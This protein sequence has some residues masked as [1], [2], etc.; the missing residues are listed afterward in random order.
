MNQS[1]ADGIPPVTSNPALQSSA[2]NP[3]QS[4]NPAEISALLNRIVTPIIQPIVNRNFTA[5]NAIPKA[6]QDTERLDVP[7]WKVNWN[8]APDNYTGY[9][10]WNESLTATEN[11]VAGLLRTILWR[12]PIVRIEPLPY[13]H[14]ERRSWAY[15]LFCAIIDV[16][17]GVMDK[18]PGP[19]NNTKPNKVIYRKYDQGRMQAGCYQVIEKL[20]E[21]HSIGASVTPSK[22]PTFKK[23]DNPGH[24]PTTPGAI[25]EGHAWYVPDPNSVV[26]RN[27]SFEERFTELCVSVTHYKT[28]ADDLIDGNDIEKV[29]YAPV[30]A[31]KCKMESALTSKKKRTEKTNNERRINN[32]VK[33][34]VQIP[35]LP[36]PGGR[37]AAGNPKRPSLQEPPRLTA[38]SALWATQRPQLVDGVNPTPAVS[39]PT[40]SPD[41]ITAALRAFLQG[42]VRESRNPP[43]VISALAQ[44]NTRALAHL[45]ARVTPILSQQQEAAIRIPAISPERIQRQPHAAVRNHQTMHDEALIDPDLTLSQQRQLSIPAQNPLHLDASRETQVARSHDHDVPDIQPESDASETHDAFFSQE[46]TASD[47]MLNYPDPIVFDNGWNVEQFMTALQVE[48]DEREVIEAEQGE[49]Q[50]RTPTINSTTNANSGMIETTPDVFNDC[51]NDPPGGQGKRWEPTPTSPQDRTPAQQ[52]PMRTN[53]RQA[54]PQR[55][56]PRNHHPMT[57]SQ[58]QTR[59]ARNSDVQEVHIRSSP[60]RANQK[61]GLAEDEEMNE[62]KRVKAGHLHGNRKE[63]SREH[64]YQRTR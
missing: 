36:V 18:F 24:N 2:P 53:I 28:I 35:M 23:K 61:R 47:Y 25:R 7:P 8:T 49:G 5:A 42:L 32:M 10:A 54:R 15:T 3:P 39:Q 58:R 30:N 62:A 26:E 17:S 63:A 41:T 60:R 37:G 46:I 45:G 50:P 16:G 19:D 14:D 40:F 6:W 64:Q 34:A 55:V 38:S 56:G 4:S 29:I 31:R 43:M 33:G 13:T 57:R 59:E 44:L 22:D 9:T 12:P 1:N 11:D 27:L 52:G 48:N 20:V 21:L 51:Y